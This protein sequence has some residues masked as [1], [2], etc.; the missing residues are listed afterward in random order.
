MN[1]IH[2]KLPGLDVCGVHIILFFNNDS[3]SLNCCSMSSNL[4]YFFAS[5][6]QRAPH[7]ILNVSMTIAQVSS[8]AQCRLNWI[9]FSFTFSEFAP[10]LI[11]NDR[12]LSDDTRSSLVCKFV[13][14]CL[15]IV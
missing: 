9:T 15:I 3:S 4:D 1:N 14:K 10:Q 8:A 5:N 2:I 6:S 7:L 13:L 11:L 12:K